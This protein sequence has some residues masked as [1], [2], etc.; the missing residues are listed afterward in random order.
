MS[1]LTVGLASNTPTFRKQKVVKEMKMIY[2]NR[3]WKAVYGAIVVAN[4]LSACAT[5][6][7]GSVVMK[8]NDTE[9]HVGMGQ[10]E[11]NVG[12]HIQLYHNACTGVGG[13][14]SGMNNRICKKE[15][16]G[17]GEVTQLLNDDYSVVKFP[18]GISFSEGD[19]IEKHTH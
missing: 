5:T 11:L 10:K 8:V 6:H 9:A 18:Q 14:R 17:H 19:T 1:S 7:R 15:F 13:G 12:D 2:P 3:A 16:T 4:F